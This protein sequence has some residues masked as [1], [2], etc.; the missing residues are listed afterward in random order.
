MPLW[1]PQKKITARTVFNYCVSPFMVYC[2]KFAPQEKKDPQNAYTNLLFEQGKAHEKQVI[3]NNYPNLKPLKYV[4]LEEGFNMLL[5]AMAK[6]AAAATGMPVFYLPEGLYGVVDVLEKRQGQ[7][8][9]FGNYYYIVKEI[10]LA[11]NIRQEHILQAAFYN[12]V[13]GKI[14]GF[15]PPSFYLINRDL[16]E[17]E[18]KFDETELL[19]TMQDIRE[20]LRGKKVAPTYGACVWPW[21]TYNNEEAVKTRDVS[22]VSGVGQSYKR[23]LNRP[24]H[25]HCRKLGENGSSKSYGNRRNRGK[26]G[27]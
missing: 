16:E 7:K 21:E 25:P 1:K 4:T 9:V 15:T 12:Y 10:K 8:S 23:R 13:I 24:Q 5:E 18:Q 22:L 27:N 11:R 17:T 19:A 6:G 26:N 2:N 14:Q 20:I 3:E